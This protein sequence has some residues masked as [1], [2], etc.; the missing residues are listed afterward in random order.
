MSEGTR[1]IS[2]N[3]CQEL[4]VSVFYHNFKLKL[5]LRSIP[6]WA[7]GTIDAPDF[8]HV[9]SR[10]MSSRFSGSFIGFTPFAY[11]KHTM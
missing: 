11:Q 2:L 5:F 8:R 4:L 7:R 10:A 9:H 6:N 3:H 1:L